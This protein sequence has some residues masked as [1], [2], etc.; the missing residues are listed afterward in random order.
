MDPIRQLWSAFSSTEK[1]YLRIYL[2]AFHRGS[3]NTALRLI[4]LLEKKPDLSQEEASMK[5]YGKK[6]TQ[7]FS[8][9]KGRVLERM[10]DVLSFS[11]NLQN[12]PL[13]KEDPVVIAKTQF[14]KHFLAALLVRKR[15]LN[16]LANELAQKA[17]H[18][19]ES[20][21]YPE[22]KLL[23]LPLLASYQS[24]RGKPVK[25]LWDGMWKAMEQYQNDLA[26]LGFIEEY[27]A[28]FA[29]HSGNE[30][31]WGEF[32]DEALENLQERLEKQYSN[33]TH[34]YYLSLLLEKASGEQDE[35]TMREVLFEMLDL[36]ESSEGM[37]QQ[38]SQTATSIRLAT[39]ELQLKRFPEALEVATKAKNTA[40]PRRSNAVYAYL[41]FAYA[42]FFNNRLEE[43]EAAATAL[44][45]DLILQAGE[46]N[47][48]I[49]AFIQS[50]LAWVRGDLM[51][52]KTHL[53]DADPLYQDKHGWN[54]GL[55]IFDIMLHIDLKKFDL[56]ESMTNNLR[57]HV[58]RYVT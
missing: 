3:E 2:E 51:V 31:E 38:N 1:R 19:S 48:G 20:L 42:A 45:E 16:D 58:Q 55:R 14:Y 43:A 21:D 15:G 34:Y 56:A 25:A 57:R 52:A 17:L 47:P 6:R 26:G 36:L 11:V 23:C 10:L 40:S 5:L 54:I 9:L 29:G 41:L 27:R 32:L 24:A 22:G 13:S 33:R 49:F 39:L 37:N 8:M 44:D 4:H 50:V 30:S 53:M 46:R 18:Q 7:A 35:D 28:R 12:H